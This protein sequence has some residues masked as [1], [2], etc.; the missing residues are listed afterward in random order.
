[1]DIADLEREIT[2]LDPEKVRLYFD[3]FQD[4]HLS[5]DGKVYPKVR[6]LRAFPLSA[7]IYFTVVRDEEGEEIGVIEDPSKLDPNSKR[8]LEVEMEKSYFMPKITQVNEITESYGVPRWD[9]ETDRGH[10]VFELRNRQDARTVGRGRVLIKDADGN[11][12]EIVDYR[13]LDTQS[14]AF[15]ET[16]L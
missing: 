4:L 12:Y 15:L 1:M 8:I 13:R 9:V 2:F 7:A 6:V 3:G 10:R 5:L 16:E 14:R 11:R